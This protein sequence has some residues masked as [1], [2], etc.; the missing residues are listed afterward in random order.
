ML[1]KSILEMESRSSDTTIMA[2]WFY[3]KRGGAAGISHDSMMRSITY[4]LL[5][6]CSRLF[7]VCRNSYRQ[8]SSLRD[9]FTR[10]LEPA[11]S[12][13]SLP[14]TVCLL[15]GLDESEDKDGDISRDIL[16]LL[17]ELTERPGSRLKV[18]VL[19]RPYNTIHKVYGTY[20]IL[21][22]AENQMDI[23]KVI[24]N[25]VDWLFRTIH[26]LANETLTPFGQARRLRLEND[27]DA[28]LQRSQEN[29]IAS[30]NSRKEAEAVRAYLKANARGVV[31][32][33]TLSLQQ[34]MR[35]ASRGPCAWADVQR[36]LHR[37][38]LELDQMYDAIVQELVTDRDQEHTLMARK[39]LA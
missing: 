8:S 18:L 14:R 24:N 10:L 16:S 4:Q 1:A 21:L 7:N 12:D 2:S 37:I 9:T 38:P 22:E 33:V 35:F 15:D 36:L 17:A 29:T 19:S 39:V 27:L 5:I 34:I 26:S 32:W 11:A 6:K 13:D 20:D 30:E 31:L 28:E 3:S 25:G 23:D